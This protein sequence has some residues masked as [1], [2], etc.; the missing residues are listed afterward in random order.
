VLFFQ[1]RFNFVRDR[2][3]LR[4]G[5]GRANHKEIGE[6]GNAG[7]IENDDLFGL[8]VRGELGAGGG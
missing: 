8:F 4:L 1:A 6:T 7:K 2:F 3:E 5:V